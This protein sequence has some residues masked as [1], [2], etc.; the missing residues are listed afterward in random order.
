MECGPY[1]PITSHD[2]HEPITSQRV[3]RACKRNLGERGPKDSEPRAQKT[4]TRQT[5]AELEKKNKEIQELQN[6]LKPADLE[7]EKFKNENKILKN[8]CRELETLNYKISSNLKTAHNKIIVLKGNIRVFCRVCPRTPKEIEQMKALCSINFIDKCTIEV[9]NGSDAVNCNG[10]LR[11]ET[12]KFSFDKVFASKASQ[13]ME[14]AYQVYFNME[15]QE[16]D[17]VKEEDAVQSTSE[18]TPKKYLCEVCNFG[19]DYNSNFHRHERSP[20]HKK[21]VE[22]YKMKTTIEISTTQKQKKNLTKRLKESE[23]LCTVNKFKDKCK[24][25]EVLISE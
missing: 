7:W 19:T 24:T 13:D 11:A 5:R 8:T 20:S 6:K 16:E 4:R 2:V 15:M 23:E 12:K 21:K 22:Q 9:G 18:K 17:A 1:W 3:D 25:Q 10:N 14:A